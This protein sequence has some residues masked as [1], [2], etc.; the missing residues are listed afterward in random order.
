M[1]SKARARR[2]RASM[3]GPR[4]SPA[5]ARARAGFAGF[6]GWRAV[7]RVTVTQKTGACERLRS[8]PVVL[9]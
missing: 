7:H 6:P 5:R 8:T 3:P 2:P 1:E 9:H 4:R